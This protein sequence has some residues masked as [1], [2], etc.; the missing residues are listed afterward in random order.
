MFWPMTQVVLAFAG[1]AVLGVLAVR[2]GIE[3]RRFA[4]AVADASERIEDAA[5][6][7]ERAAAPLATGGGAAYRAYGD[8]SAG[9]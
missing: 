8:R 1:V 5:A 4:R 9:E 3:V 6:E 2:V 7:L